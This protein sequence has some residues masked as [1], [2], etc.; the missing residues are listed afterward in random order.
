MGGPGVTFRTSK[1]KRQ[2]LYM[3]RYS[4]NVRGLLAWST[5]RDLITV[6][7]QFQQSRHQNLFLDLY[8]PTQDLKIRQSLLKVI[9]KKTTYCKTVKI[10]VQLQFNHIIKSCIHINL[11]VNIYPWLFVL[12]FIK[13][14]LGICYV[15]GMVLSTRDLVNKRDKYLFPAKLTLYRTYRK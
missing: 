3:S 11:G 1:Q 13:Y 4:N 9:G 8:N 7:K 14:L 12:L 6:I 15:P 10:Y 2:S 5:Q